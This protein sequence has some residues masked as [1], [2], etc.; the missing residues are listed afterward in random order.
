MAE[1]IQA[2]DLLTQ[3]DADFVKSGELKKIAKAIKRDHP[4][5]MQL[6]ASGKFYPRMLAVLIMDKKLLTQEF[7][8]VL[9]A[10]LDMHPVDERVQIADWLLANQLMK[11]K[12][13]IALLESWREADAP[14]LR[15]LYWYHQGRLRWTGKTPPD[16]TVQ[17]LDALE[18][19]LISEEPEVQWT[20]NFTAG[21]IG[22]FDKAHRAQCIELGERVGLYKGE[23]VPRG[24]TP[25]YLPEFIRIEAAKR[26]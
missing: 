2:Q 10:D 9:V 20:M 8:D 17:L 7:L 4:L 5:A 1:A 25:S 26:E 23:P 21:W 3:L 19:D 12:P 14:L 15:R 13:T 24:C 18:T 22:V 6:W 16:N 11:S